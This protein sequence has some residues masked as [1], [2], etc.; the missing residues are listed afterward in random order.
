MKRCLAA[1]AVVASLLMTASPAA[2]ADTY[3]Y[4]MTGSSASASWTNMPAGV[5]QLPPGQYWQTDV[6]A[7]S[8][9]EGAVSVQDTMGNGLCVSYWTFA[10]DANGEWI[11]G[12]SVSACDAEAQIVFDPRLRSDR[13]VGTIPIMECTAWDDMTGECVGEWVQT[14]TFAV[15]LTLTGTGPTY[16]T[17]GTSSGGT[18]GM[19]QYTSHGTS[20]ERMAVASGTVTYNGTS[21][22]AGATA[23]SGTLWTSKNGYVEI[24]ICNAKTGC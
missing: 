16:R 22:T 2:A 3:H 23:Q 4:R 5:D 1:I 7:G 10:I 8:Q 19:S 14:G 6:F 13:L 18:A 21:I 24:T 12:P 15:D 9:V 20:Q 11:D 17:H